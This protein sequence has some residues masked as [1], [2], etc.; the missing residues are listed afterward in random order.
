MLPSGAPTWAN[1]CRTYRT[2]SGWLEYPVL[3]MLRSTRSPVGES[4][5]LTGV[6]HPSWAPRL[7]FLLMAAHLLL[8]CLFLSPFAYFWSQCLRAKV[9]I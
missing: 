8:L 5:G 7:A 6:R 2:Q 9:A 4:A 1:T 3:W